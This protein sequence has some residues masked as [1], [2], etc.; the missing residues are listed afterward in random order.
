MKVKLKSKRAFKDKK[1]KEWAKQLEI[2]V[3]N[4]GT[5]PIY[6]LNLSFTLDDFRLEDGHP[7]AFAIA[8]GRSELLYLDTPL[9]PEDVP[10]ASCH[11]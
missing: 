1:N 10:A 6:Y 3:K 5:K 2:E 9:I 7:I 8:Y 11:G 4:T